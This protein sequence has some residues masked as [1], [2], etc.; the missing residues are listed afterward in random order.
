MANVGNLLNI[1][2]DKLFEQ[3]SI[4]EIDQVHKRLQAEVELKREELRTM[5]G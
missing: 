1:N 5:V 2:V 4:A 3:H